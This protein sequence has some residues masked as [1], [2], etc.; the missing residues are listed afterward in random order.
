[1]RKHKSFILA[2]V[3]LRLGKPNLLLKGGEQA[4]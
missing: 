4:K 1:M 2:T 3:R